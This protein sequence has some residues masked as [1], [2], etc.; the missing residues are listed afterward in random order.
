MACH[1]AT[2]QA[3]APTGVRAGRFVSGGAGLGGPLHHR[4]LFHHCRGLANSL[5][6]ADL[7]DC[8]ASSGPAN[9]LAGNLAPSRLAYSAPDLAPSPAD[10]APGLPYSATDLAPRAT[11]LSTS[12]TNLATYR[13]PNLAARLASHSL[14]SRHPS[15][16]LSRCAPRGTGEIHRSR[17]RARMRVVPRTRDEI[18]VWGRTPDKRSIVTNSCKVTRKN[19]SRDAFGGA[20]AVART[21][22]GSSAS[23]RGPLG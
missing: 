7:P 11:D 6:A 9:G 18:E 17:P 4:G 1:G 23:A 16:H 10:L 3:A 8:L 20:R 14:P 15:D 13:A 21:G 2:L 22:I 19:A 12:R 5:A